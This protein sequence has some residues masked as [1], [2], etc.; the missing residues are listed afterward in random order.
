VLRS[1]ERFGHVDAGEIE[2][3]EASH[4]KTPSM[5]VTMAENITLKTV[6]SVRWN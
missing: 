6:R 1:E 2:N 3:A 5:A 4:Q